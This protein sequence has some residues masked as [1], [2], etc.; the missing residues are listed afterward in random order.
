M[1]LAEPLREPDTV[2]NSLER[3]KFTYKLKELRMMFLTV[4]IFSTVIQ[5]YKLSLHLSR[6][7]TF[8]ENLHSCLPV[9]LRMIVSQLTLVAFRLF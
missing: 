5:G 7:Q 4:Q 1:N 9:L 2:S 8:E 3:V 6:T